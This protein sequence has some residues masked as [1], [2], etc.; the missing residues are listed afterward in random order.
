MVTDKPIKSNPFEIVNVG[1]IYSKRSFL[2]IKELKLLYLNYI[3]NKQFLTETE[4]NVMGVFL[5]SCFTGLRYSA[6]LSLDAS[7]I[8]DRKIRQQTARPQ[9]HRND[10]F[11][12]KIRRHQNPTQRSLTTKTCLM[13]KPQTKERLRS[14][15]SPRNRKVGMLRMQ[16]I[17]NLD[18]IQ[19]PPHRGTFSVQIRKGFQNLEAF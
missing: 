6:P 10:S 5:F 3:D 15:H 2:T 14:A 13:E 18:F 8:F 12:R 7:E 4:Q 17:K 16:V 11:L 9:Q 1:R 19:L